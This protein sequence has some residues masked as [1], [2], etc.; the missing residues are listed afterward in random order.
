[1]NNIKNK[2][3]LILLIAVLALLS[4]IFIS[5]KIQKNFYNKNSKKTEAKVNKK[6]A[7]IKENEKNTASANTEKSND[8]KPDPEGKKTETVQSKGDVPAK[9][10]AASSSTNAADIASKEKTQTNVQDSTGKEKTQTNEPSKDWITFNDSMDAN[11]KVINMADGG[12]ILYK[13]HVEV[14]CN[15]KSVADVTKRALD[16]YKINCYSCNSNYF[17]MILG[18]SEKDYGGLSGW[19]YYISLDNINFKKYPISSGDYIYQN[20]DY[21][22]W[23]YWKDAV[24]EK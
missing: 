19:N 14:N 3:P 18:I 22:T 8:T 5:G 16:H 20:G 1:M 7:E 12:K 6:V 2:K 15:N 4:L 17:S 21:I 23:K 10:A 24:N 13:T 11:F 9:G